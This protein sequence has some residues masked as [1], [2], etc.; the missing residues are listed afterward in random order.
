MKRE[1]ERERERKE[2]ARASHTPNP[3]TEEVSEQPRS[4]RIKSNQI[5]SIVCENREPSFRSML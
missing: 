5:Y 4:N 3:Q 1:R 2:G